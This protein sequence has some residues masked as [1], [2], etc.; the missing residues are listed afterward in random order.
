MMD[1]STTAMPQ[2]GLADPARRWFRG[3][4][5]LILTAVA[6][7][8]GRTWFGWP[9][10]AAAGIAPVLLSLA[11]CAAMCAVGICTMKACSKPGSSIPADTDPAPVSEPDGSEP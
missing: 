1:L 2:S 3:R 7:A 8:G 4:R 6:V 10:L 11:P 5:A 9:W